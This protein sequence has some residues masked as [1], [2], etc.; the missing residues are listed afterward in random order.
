[1]PN[2][3]EIEKYI[4]AQL[5]LLTTTIEESTFEKTIEQ[6]H[7]LLDKASFHVYCKYLKRLINIVA[8]DIGSE[9][10]SSESALIYKL[11]SFEL[12]YLTEHP[13]L[14][15][16]FGFCLPES[17]SL[18]KFFRFFS[19]SN[20]EKLFLCL[21]IEACKEDSLTDQLPKLYDLYFPGVKVHNSAAF[22]SLFLKS[23]LSLSRKLQ[24]V[25][26]FVDDE[27][28]N[29]FFTSLRQMSLEQLL[30][31]I[32][33]EVPGRLLREV[34]TTPEDVATVLTEVLVPGSQFGKVTGLTPTD[35]AEATARGSQLQTILQPLEL[36]YHSVVQG[37]LSRLEESVPNI[38]V[39]S[40]SQF[41]CAL[42]V[43]EEFF[44][45]CCNNSN[46]ELQKQLVTNLSMLN[47]QQGA[48]DLTRFAGTP[49][50]ASDTNTRRSILYFSCFARLEVLT[51]AHLQANRT[52][53]GEVASVFDKDYR[54][55]PEYVVC[56]CISLLVTP[57][58]SQTAETSSVISVL[59][60]SLLIQLLDI[61]SPYLVTL[62]EE[63]VKVGPAKVAQF[64]V[65]YYERR[66]SDLTSFK[67]A[68]LAMATSILADVVNLL[69]FKEALNVAMD[70]VKF[71][72]D[73]LSQFVRGNLNSDE[74]VLQLLIFLENCN[75]QRESRPV[76]GMFTLL[77]LLS[78]SKIPPQYVERFKAAQAQTIQAFPRLINFG[79]GH[80]EAILAN[81]KVGPFFPV[82]VEQEMKM[83]YQKMY[84]KQCDIKE[85]I[86]M[87]QQM[88]DSDSPHDQ[89]I[90]ACMIHSLV[91]EYRFFP[92]YPVDALATTSVL[93]G[94]MILFNLVQGNTLSIGLRYILESAR[95][96]VESNMF[97]FALQALL[98]MR[99]RLSEFPKYC[100]L[101]AEIPALA[102]RNE[103]NLLSSPSHA[104]VQP[105]LQEE[106]NFKSLHCSAVGSF[107]PPNEEVSDRILFMINNLS[108]ENLD[109]N[110]REIASLL[111]TPFLGWFASYLVK[112]RVRSE[113]NFHELYDQLCQNIGRKVDRFIE[114]V[115][116]AHV[117]LL[118]NKAYNN[119]MTSSEKTQLK[120]LALWVGRITLARDKPL[121]HKHIALK[122]LLVE[123]HDEGKLDIVIPFVCKILSQAVHSRV[124]QNPNPWILGVLQVL[125]ELYEVSHLSLNLRFEIELL[126]TAL[127]V[128]HVEPS[129]IV[130]THSP[131]DVA[132]S[133]EV[134]RQLAQVT[135]QVSEMAVSSPP[136]MFADLVGESVWVTHPN[137]RRL[138]QTAMT[139]SV[140]SVL[141]VIVERTNSIALGT[142]MSLVMKDFALE[143]D[144][145]KIRHAA[146]MVSTSLCQNLSLA[147]VREPL[148]ES[149]SQNLLS[150]AQLDA[151]SVNAVPV[152]V[153]DNIHLAS[154]LIQKASMDRISQEVDEAVTEVLRHNTLEKNVSRY[155]LQLPEPLGLRPTGVSPAQFAIYENFNGKEV[156]QQQSPEAQLTQLMHQLFE[157][158]K[159]QSSSLKTVIQ[160]ILSVVSTNQEALALR[161]A[162][163]AVQLLFTQCDT[164]LSKEALVF[165]LEKLCEMSPSTAKDVTWW[166]VHAQDERKY[167]A[168]V[169]ATLVK[170][171]L[172]SAAELDKPL[173][174]IVG[175]SESAS[176]F[177]ASLVA[178]LVT[179]NCVMKSQFVYSIEAMRACPFCSEQVTKID[180]HSVPASSQEAQ[181]AYTFGEWTKLVS[182]TRGDP[183][184]ALWKER[185]VNSIEL[186]VADLIR[187]STQMAVSA[188]MQKQSDFS[189]CDALAELMVY[190]DLRVCLSI[191]TLVLVAEHEK[192]ANCFN[193]RPFFRIF[194]TLLAQPD[195]SPLALAETL[196]VVQPVVC[197]GFTFAW[198]SLV[199]H[200]MF[201]PKILQSNEGSAKFVSLLLAL[202]KFQK[203]QKSSEIVNVVFKGITRI[204]TLLLHDFPDFLVNHHY[205]LSTAIPSHYTQL[206]NIV[207][208]AFPRQMV[209][210]DPYEPLESSDPAIMAFNPALDLTA[211]NARKF[212]DNYLRIPSSIKSILTAL[213][214]DS[215]APYDARLVNALVIHVGVSATQN[216]H[217]TESSTHV[218]L[219][220]AILQEDIVEL[221]SMVLDA[222][223][224]QL[225]YPNSLTSWCGQLMLYL[226]R[227]SSGDVQQIIARI[228]LERVLANKPHPWGITHTFKELVTSSNLFEL[229]FVHATPEIE[230]LFETLQ[231]NAVGVY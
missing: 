217:F 165:L 21:G 85:V 188:F 185:F 47:P 168:D 78:S 106:S 145:T 10:K 228:L 212:I 159:T 139:K 215:D 63:Y 23:N 174:L 3:L 124:F 65:S 76:E 17:I 87:L 4:L 191:V 43:P 104:P 158:A 55:V 229:P 11:V 6:I 171:D 222:V 170:M 202:F 97:K 8:V 142:A 186:D 58:S 220:S 50:M 15:S 39:A 67:V 219:I 109:K 62:F 80:D 135:R 176:T 141:P 26:Y 96:P 94:S 112:E 115:T 37:I 190:T 56:A 95:Q 93:F 172:V 136:P 143:H 38:S 70:G 189:C 117:V 98:A 101:L 9:S 148:R 92:E 119:Q 199:S 157:A 164:P 192:G 227:T 137:L 79:T 49:I 31:Q 130:R 114:E 155:A 213:E 69:P 45:E 214:S 203:V 60:E 231:R 184:A 187:L 196:I 153:N 16:N 208:S 105:P 48:V 14:V 72:Y 64:L 230:K 90:F 193:Q 82:Q 91:D 140:A 41:L 103:L 25:Q 198:I 22:Q 12:K 75:F 225:R 132:K 152:A 146:H 195:I 205:V 30:S 156:P 129:H 111:D 163:N 19:L 36:N 207:L 167:H 182:H 13:Y 44:V 40:L 7:H 86:S 211:K 46:L 224:N 51:V 24:L 218:S 74:N 221:Q 206:R 154:E 204:L 125:K 57:V 120:N 61:N 181:L 121:K 100:S 169:M 113:P 110:G 161:A 128:E 102:S 34:L 89:D 52:M 131:N 127:K 1:M 210:P 35:V 33:S 144:E 84:N 173:S 151:A 122:M 42:P 147:S 178:A 201:L 162:Q 81:A 194:S 29:V 18:E 83:A 209:L 68:Q 180:T 166:L 179:D 183:S 5:S 28:T 118:T 88:K 126:F 223:A 32:P 150:I 54:S 149:I 53:A 108:F 138:L 99:V 226:F 123:A 20:F 59:L 200:R 73:Q 177:V 160:T 133:A 27:S 2:E 116:M 77:E 175:T 216:A 107:T 66:T 71:G 197:P 134:T